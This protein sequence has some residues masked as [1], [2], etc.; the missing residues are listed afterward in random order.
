MKQNWFIAGE[1]SQNIGPF[2]STQLKHLAHA[3]RLTPEDFL[4]NGETGN[5]V[6]AK[7]VQGLFNDSSLQLEKIP[8][9]SL[10]KLPNRI[11]HSSQQTGSKISNF[12]LT[13][14][15]L[16]SAVAMLLSGGVILFIV[17]PQLQEFAISILMGGGVLL[18]LGWLLAIASRFFGFGLHIVALCF[19]LI[20]GGTW[21][22][23]RSFRDFREFDQAGEDWSNGS[24]KEA[25][26]KYVKLLAFGRCLTPENRSL[27]YGRVIDHY[28]S[29][30]EREKATEIIFASKR[31]GVKPLVV[32]RQAQEMVSGE[33]SEDDPTVDFDVFD[34]S[35]LDYA[36]GPQGQPVIKKE[37]N[38]RTVMEVSRGYTGQN[39]VWYPHGK[40][41]L[42]GLGQV[43]I[44]ESSFACGRKHGEEILKDLESN[45]MLKKSLYHGGDLRR[46]ETWERGR[47]VSDESFLNGEL[48]GTS[49]KW[50][51]FGRM[52]SQESFEQ[53]KL[54]GWKSVWDREGKLIYKARFERGREVELSNEPFLGK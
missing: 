43:L 9:L 28:A 29:E 30:N 53:G 6:S 19:F 27:A 5:P 51:E 21:I 17:I 2:S 52:L 39:G 20:G 14:S 50:N 34:Y 25:V 33:I 42:F 46:V 10:S 15:V 24:Q 7:K 1:N 32:T 44:S 23:D 45:A 18:M 11:Q 3:G 47:K 8:P 40:Q 36:K 49:M 4:K 38:R 37:V 35:K 16:C 12:L 13:V 22:V 48:H 26:E 31:Q 54:H 41:E